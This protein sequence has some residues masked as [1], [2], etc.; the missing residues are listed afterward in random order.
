MRN[1]RTSLNLFAALLLLLAT[2]ASAQ[3]W[4]DTDLGKVYVAGEV[5]KPGEIKYRDGMHVE[6]AL[7]AAKGINQLGSSRTIVILRKTKVIVVDIYNEEDKQVVIH[8]GDLVF[9]RAKHFPGK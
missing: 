8:D 9:V 2:P 3:L 1:M 4:Q 5:N 7:E 6:D